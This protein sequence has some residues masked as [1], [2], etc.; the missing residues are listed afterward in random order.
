MTPELE[1]RIARLAADRESGASEILA[2]AIAILRDA[3]TQN[4]DLREIALALQRAQ[5][6][7]APMWNATAAALTG[8]LDRFAERV[9]RA[10]RA[11]ARFAADL[12]ETGIESDAPLRIATLSYSATV[13]H[14]L[15]ALARRRGVHVACS[16]GR[17]ALEGRRLATR[18][19][20]AG[21]AVTCYVDAAIGQALD[22]TDAV[23][24]GADAITVEWFLNKSGTHMLAAAAVQRGVPV[25]VL[26]GREKFASPAV[27]ADLVPRGGPPDEVWRDPPSAVAVLNPYFER[28]PL[29]L[30]A[31][32]VA[33]VGILGSGDVAE[34]CTHM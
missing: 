3:P 14:T 6:S 33:D 17:P 29:E 9:A 5:P 22:S 15:E 11:I 10:P 2:A 25:Y 13:A 24:V 31:A 18:L 4:A 23:L 28:V 20:A 1:K 19:A 26:A 8:D 12:M 27:A 7:M 34:V 30:V 21:V 32:V 16:E